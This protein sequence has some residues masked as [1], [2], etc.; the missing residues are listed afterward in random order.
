MKSYEALISKAERIL[1]TAAKDVGLNNESA[2]CSL[3]IAE[4]YLDL[5]HARLMVDEAARGH[6]FTYTF[7]D[8]FTRGEGASNG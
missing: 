8:P 4:S 5:I 6:G 7:A 1:S 2:M 3:A